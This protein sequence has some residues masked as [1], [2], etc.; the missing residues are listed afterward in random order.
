MYNQKCNERLNSY[1]KRLKLYCL[2]AFSTHIVLQKLHF[3]NKKSA[4]Q[5]IIHVSIQPQA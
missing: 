4:R 1:P 2:S 3:Q 5:L